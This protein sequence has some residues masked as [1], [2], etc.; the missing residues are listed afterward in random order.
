MVKQ[1]PRKKEFHSLNSAREIGI[2]FDTLNDRNYAIVK[3]FSED[4]VRQ[5]F[6]VKTVGWTKKDEL[7]LVDDVQQT[8]FYTSK[9]I[10]LFSEKDLKWTGQPIMPEIKEFVASPFNLLFVLTEAKEIPVQ[11]IA[12]L[13]RASCKVG[14]F[15]GDCEHLD[16]I[17]DQKQDKSLENLIAESLKYLSQIKKR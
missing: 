15:A 6:S 17:I 8:L 4:L 12:R 13:S 11:Y 14:S 3:K 16:L 10:V 2:L 7:P 9:D 5:G 1:N